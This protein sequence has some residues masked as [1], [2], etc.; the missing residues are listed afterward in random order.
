MVLEQWDLP[1]QACRTDRS[2]GTD[3]ASFL[4]IILEDWA[5]AE[6][7]LVAEWQD[8]SEAVETVQGKCCTVENKVYWV[9][10]L[11]I[12]NI[13]TFW[14]LE[15]WQSTAVEMLTSYTLAQLLGYHVSWQA[16]LC[17]HQQRSMT[18]PSGQTCIEKKC[19]SLCMI[20]WWVRNSDRGQILYDQW[21]EKNNRLSHEAELLFSRPDSWNVTVALH[22]TKQ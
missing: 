5:W 8:S 13:E 12:R 9:Q 11:K 14:R 3:T 2:C 21:L 4:E 10:L 17:L 20:S 19:N 6:V 16:E 18:W 15:L 22:A 7:R 1:F